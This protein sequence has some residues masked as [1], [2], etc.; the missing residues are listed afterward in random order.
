VK[1]ILALTLT[2]LLV[3]AVLAP[4]AA[5]AQEI[6]G[7]TAVNVAEGGGTPPVVMCKWEQQP[8]AVNPNYEDSDPAHSIPGFQ[9]LP[10][11]AACATKTI[12][13]YAVV[14][15]NESG[16]NVAQVFADVYHP[17]GSPEPYG[18]SVVGGVWNDNEGLPYFKYE[19]KFA[20]SELPK[21]EQA[22]MVYD[23]WLA[24]LIEFGPDMD[25]EEVIRLINKGTAKVWWGDEEIDYEQPAGMYNVYDFAVDSN[26]NLSAP[27]HNQFL[28]EPVCGIDVDF[29]SI[30]WGSTDLGV[31]KMVPGDT[32]WGN[33]PINNATVRNV[34][35]TYVSPMVKFSD[36]GFGKDSDNNWN[37]QFDA[38]M[39]DPDQYYV[40]DIMP[41]TWVTLPNA[42]D[43]SHMDELDFSILIHK[44][45]GA[46]SGTI[47]LGCVCRPFDWEEYGEESPYYGPVSNVG[48]VSARDLC[49]PIE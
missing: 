34:G 22:D 1:K 35:N 29:T 32:I 37:V 26:N 25:I 11:L 6:P 47:T 30:N 3:I 5:L 4:T 45:F 18:P 16:G 38:R 44:G 9:L 23:A 42:L 7:T 19:V 10:P 17:E 40:G 33:G 14:T 49:Q 31:E 15:D 41:E 2:V 48:G 24:G 46:H 39:G 28:Y 43:L 20:I 36:M 27:L 13:Y 12:E 21:E 8:L